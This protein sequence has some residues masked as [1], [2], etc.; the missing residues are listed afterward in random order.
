[1]ISFNRPEFLFAIL[2]TML[3]GIPAI[4]EE[5]KLK[6]VTAGSLKLRVPENWKEV[7]REF[8]FSG[9]CTENACG[10]MQYFC[11]GEGEIDIDW[12]IAQ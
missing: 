2:V 11:P 5:T 1:M 6:S 8:L 4:G 7:R 12:G 9:I 3:I 10:G